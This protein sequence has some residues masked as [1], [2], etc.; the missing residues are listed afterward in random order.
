MA[1]TIWTILVCA[2]STATRGADTDVVI[3]EI[4]YHAPFDLDELQYIE[5]FNR[6]SAEVDLSGWSLTKGIK[7]DFPDKTRLAAGGYL[8]VCRKAELLRA[9]Y[10]GNMPV[11]G[12]FCGRMSH[13]GERIELCNSARTLIDSVKYGD[14]EPW[15]LG[16]DGYSASLERI[17]PFAPGDNPA[18]W[19]GS[20]L[21]AFEKLA[22]TPGRRNDSFSTNLPPVIT[23]T[24]CSPHGPMKPVTVTAQVGDNRG[25]R[26]V[27]LL[28]R[29]AA[30]GGEGAEKAV[31]MQRIEGDER[32]GTY[33]AAIPGQPAGKL[34]RWRLKAVNTLGTVRFVP[35]PSEPRPTYSYS[36][37]VNTNS[38]RIP[39]AYVVN[40]TPQQ[41]KSEARVWNG[42]PF[43]VPADPTHGNA[44]FIY[45]PPGGS[46]VVT[47][48]YVRV[49]ERKGGFKAHFLKDQTF[50]GMTGINVIFEGSPRWLL[51]EPMAYELYR[52]AGVPACLTEHLR[53]WEDGQPQGYRLL[54]EQPNKAFLTRNKRDGRGYLY[55]VNYWNQGLVGQ[56]GKR[57]RYATTHQ[58]LV[59]LHRSLTSS[60]ASAQW[61]Y[62]RQH[63]NVE[64][65]IGYYAVNMCIQNWDG[66]FNNYYLYHDAEGTG[67]WEMYPWDEDKTW[68]DYDGAS[69][70]YDWYSMPLTFGSNE[71]GSHAGMGF[72]GGGMG[73][74]AGGWWRPPGWFSGPLLANLEF[75]RAFLARLKDICTQSFTGAKMIPLIDAMEHRL[76][77]EIERGALGSFHR[78]IQ[79]LRNQ[80][81]N[82]RQF[83]LDAIPKDRA[84]R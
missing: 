10:G 4:M 28:W 47:Y 48:D 19:A 25:V 69:P 78:D 43:Q 6:G 30:S 67:K 1:L 50:K 79:S 21:P 5:L 61:D 59:A 65:F 11:I 39:F 41:S 8:V 7:Y 22:G 45:A 32:S 40:V 83:I 57:T 74:G 60:S 81:K 17:C 75:R 55:K 3:N 29:V 76:E 49:R 56:H 36:T 12:G 13:H 54:I 23:K 72:G 14:H 52:L 71:S 34:V 9:N 70:N 35:A 66:F 18:N 2:F 51:S 77:P 44:A 63:F 16:P 82:R 27:A 42:K 20:S 58:D 31:S 26:E 73:F 37:L 53:V 80:V 38:A 84:S 33:Q 64:E 68:G 46:E 15:P 62:I 24:Q